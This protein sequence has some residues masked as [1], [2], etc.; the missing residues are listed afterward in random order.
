MTSPVAQRLYI[1]DVTLRDGMHAIRHRIDPADVGRIAAALDAAG[2]DAIEVA[3]GDGLAGGSVN[4]GPGSHTDWAWIEAAASNV[5]NAVLTT[6]PPAPR[7]ICRL[8]CS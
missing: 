2:V 4:Y 7:V 8:R 1:Q 6:L 3:H 5:K